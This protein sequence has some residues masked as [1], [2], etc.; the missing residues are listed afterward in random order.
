MKWRERNN[1][2]FIKYIMGPKS[3]NLPAWLSSTSVI[4]P[5]TL[6]IFIQYETKIKELKNP[7]IGV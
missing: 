2:Y 6:N 7:I 3:N 4:N 1:M 5:K